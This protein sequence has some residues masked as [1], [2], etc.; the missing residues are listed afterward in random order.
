LLIFLI[1]IAIIDKKI[2]QN[3]WNKIFQNSIFLSKFLEKNRFINT[4]KNL[5]IFLP[6]YDDCIKDYENF[7]W[8]IRVNCLK[9]DSENFIV[10]LFGNSYGEHLTPVLF[11]IPSITLIHSRFENGFLDD[12]KD[13]SI[14]LNKILLQYDQITKKY[15][16]KIII[17]SLNGTKYSDKSIE[18]L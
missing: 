2:I 18:N 4:E 3:T 15:K 1:Y 11:S 7:S 8:S 10:Y 12:H 9:D 14:N 13:L 17:I 5:K 6:R 16:T